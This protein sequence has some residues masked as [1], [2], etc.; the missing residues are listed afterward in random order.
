MEVATADGNYWL[1][2]NDNLNSAPSLANTAHWH[3]IGPSTVT[4]LYGSEV[5]L[6]AY[7]DSSDYL[8]GNQVSAAGNLFLCVEPNG[9]TY[10]LSAPPSASWQLMGPSAAASKVGVATDIGTWSPTLEYDPSNEV[11]YGGYYY[12]ALQQNNDVV[13]GTDDT[14]WQRGAPTT[15]PPPTP[16][17]PWNTLTQYAVGDECTFTPDT[18]GS[19]SLTGTA[20]SAA[21]VHRSGLTQNTWSNPAY[22]EGTSSYATATLYGSSGTVNQ[23]DWLQLT[24]FT[25]FA[26]LPAGCS[27]VG[28][29]VSEK[30]AQT[31]GTSATY[32]DTMTF[33][34]LTG[35]VKNAAPAYPSGGWTGTPST[36]TYGGAKDSWNVVITPAMLQA[37]GFG[38]KI[39]CQCT[40]SPG[41]G[42][43]VKLNSVSVTVYYVGTGIASLNYYKCVVGNS[44]TE[45]DTNP[46]Y[47]MLVGPLSLSAV[48]DSTIHAKTLATALTYGQV[49]LSKTGVIG[50]NLA[51]VSDA[52]N[53]VTNPGFES[54]SG[55]PPTGWVA[56]GSLTCSY[57][58]TTQYQGTQSVICS[59]GQWCGI[60]TSTANYIPVNANQ[61]YTFGWMYKITSGALV[62]N[63]QIFWYDSSHS[64]ISNPG[65]GGGTA[66][67]WTVGAFAATAPSNAVWARVMLYNS[68]A[69]SGTFEVDAV[70]FGARSAVS[71]TDPNG[72]A[73]TDFTQAHTGKVLSNISDDAFYSKVGASSVTAGVPYTLKGPWTSGNAYHVGDEV[74][75]LGNF[76][77]CAVANTAGVI[78][79]PS[80]ANGWWTRLGAT[81]IDSVE[82]G[83]TYAKPL[84][85]Y[86][87]AG[88]PYSLKGA[89]SSGAT[90]AKGDEVTQ[91]GVYYISIQGS[92]SGHA[93]NLSGSWWT[94]YGPVTLDDIVDNTYAKPLATALTSG[95]VDLS[96]GGVIGRTGANIVYSSGGA[97]LDSLMPYEAAAT[98]GAR[99]GTNLRSAA[100]TVLNDGD[101]ITS[102]GT[103]NN[104]VQVTG[105][106]VPAV[107]SSGLLLFKNVAQAN[108]SASST[109]SSTLVALTGATTTITTHGKHVLVIVSGSFY[110]SSAAAD[111]EITWFMDGTGGHP[112][113]QVATTEWVPGSIV[114]VV[115]PAAGSHTFSV[116]WE[117]VGGGTLYGTNV[118]IQAIEPRLGENND[119]AQHTT[120]PSI[121]VQREPWQTPPWLPQRWTSTIRRFSSFSCA[122]T[123]VTI[124]QALRHRRT[125]PER[126]SP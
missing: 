53:P 107:D 115:T 62:I 93:P 70:T 9:P 73:L 100:G 78:N 109:T 48:A 76:W 125:F 51:N 77:K 101:V 41:T 61:T 26:S 49:N 123:Q 37:S 104:T 65:S 38:V 17:Q 97:T 30:H 59:V 25:G 32:I 34:G 46:T 124:P 22:A 43:N 120:C 118:Y 7:S 122:A 33:L 96:K 108:G 14:M 24:N 89:Y 110:I 66:T 75:N 19:G 102:Q 86:L 20:T 35:T 50:K 74:T 71:A 55:N 112:W 90:Y 105:G 117:I 12:Q 31:S 113:M 63:W 98:V 103:S 42:A 67:A 80:I 29:V 84:A 39:G 82:D 5:F 44:N 2:V 94:P 64:Q 92:N 126:T 114:Y 72:L 81:S 16:V 36:I 58:T 10:G 83:T 119:Y 99:S 45:P 88:V 13:P 60:F 18:T 106:T 11:E 95:Q 23:S 57:D 47:W 6:G 68:A 15:A 116:Y 79:R 1:A 54:G 27:I 56:Q 69:A 85:S 87:T 121:A 28:L 91:A 40:R 111:G 8:D 21:S 52:P 4:A 3:I